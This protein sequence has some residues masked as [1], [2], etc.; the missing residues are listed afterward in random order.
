MATPYTLKNNDKKSFLSHSKYSAN[1]ERVH[2]MYQKYILGETIVN[3]VGF[4]LRAISLS[5]ISISKKKISQVLIK[6]SLV[7][8]SR[9]IKKKPVLKVPQI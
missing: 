5:K 6:N 4:N 3:A 7:C 2:Q 1:K 9:L 8:F